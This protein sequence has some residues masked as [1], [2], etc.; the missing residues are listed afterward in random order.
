MMISL[1]PLMYQHKPQEQ[2]NLTHHLLNDVFEGFNASIIAEL[3]QEH[4]V[5]YHVMVQLDDFLMKNR[6]LNRFRKYTK[7]FG[8]KSC[9]QVQ[10][11]DSYRAYLKKSI[12]ETKLVI[13]DPIIRDYYG[14]FKMS[15]F[16]VFPLV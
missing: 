10:Y 6:L 14:I 3:T 5:H 4:N 16:E 7:I 13:H 15:T 9:T 1:K 8:K 12:D 11:E 2:Y